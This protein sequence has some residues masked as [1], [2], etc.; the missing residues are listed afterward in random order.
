[1]NATIARIRRL[2]ADA[3]PAGDGPLLDAFLAGDQAAFAALVRRHAGLVFATCRRVLRHR[4]DAEDAFQ[5]TFLVLARRAAA[6][7][8]REAVGAWLFGVANRVALKARTAR[9]RRAGREQPLEEVASAERPAPDFDLADAVHR[10]V[11][12]LPEVYRAAVVACDL[13]GLSRK[14]AAERLGWTE[15]TLS[16]RLARARDLLARRLRR[17][18]LSLPAGLVT[19]ATTEGVSASAVQTTIDLATG[20]AGGASAPVAALTEGVVWSMALIKLKAMAAA[21]FAACA[22]GFG[23]FAATGAGIGDGA[24][25]QPTQ[26]APVA[27]VAA[28]PLDPPAKPIVRLEKPASD[29]D[30]LQGSWRATSIQEGDRIAL[31]E[32]KDPWVIEIS[33]S[34]MKMPYKDATGG[35]KQRT[36]KIAVDGAKQ[37][38]TIDLT[39]AS[40]PV[41]RGIYEF[42]APAVTC[43]SC[44]T[45]EVAGKT[46]P[47]LNVVGMCGP[48]L[49]VAKPANLHLRLALSVDG[50]RPAKF[51]GEGVIV[52]DLTRIADRDDERAKLEREA[53]LE[54]ERATLQYRQA[55][56]QVEN[57]QAKHL[58]ATKQLK[59]AKDKLV[60]AEKAAADLKKPQPGPPAKD[61]PVFTVHVRTLADAEKV[62]RVKLTGDQTVLDAFVHATAVG[63]KASAASAWV[64]RGDTIFPVDLAA[65]TKYGDTKT[66]YQLLAGDKLFVQAKPPM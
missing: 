54:V 22:L 13:E 21:V 64:V 18:G 41:A 44:H 3:L 28:K 6:V 5:A 29:L 49:K 10:A 1:M 8:P 11:L 24:G 66:N 31:T 16:G 14:E 35:W 4:Q 58:D 65:L 23:A 53:A 42:T 47:L 38:R 62:I 51:G 19:L 32:P 55:A 7:W 45:N 56:V 43:A 57:A 61:G 27:P 9:T 15:G 63:I 48:G 34:T 59:E 33:G 30:L 12:K 60:A 36:Y 20:T 17:S 39:D 46:V 2:T 37:P 52:F 40:N 50:K 26:G 25:G